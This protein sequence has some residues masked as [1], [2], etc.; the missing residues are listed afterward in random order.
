MKKLR[1]SLLAATLL[2]GSGL[3]SVE[4]APGGVAGPPSSGG[5]PS[6]E[7]NAILGLMLA[8]GTVAFLRRTKNSKA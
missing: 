2:L 4:A 7:I 1:K 5:A 8:A 6:A 3:V